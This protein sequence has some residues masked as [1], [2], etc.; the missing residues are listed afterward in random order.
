MVT[1][2]AVEPGSP[3]VLDCIVVDANQQVVRARGHLRI[4]VGALTT[5][6]G[7]AAILQSW[8]NNLAKDLL[9]AGKA[10]RVAPSNIAEE[11][12]KELQGIVSKTFFGGSAT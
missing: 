9:A 3:T 1:C 4:N 10:E 11:R 7:A 5:Y 12:A 6:E 2:L 8:A